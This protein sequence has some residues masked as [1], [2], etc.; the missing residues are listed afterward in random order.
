MSYY[1]F[2]FSEIYLSFFLN[3]D[4]KSLIFLSLPFTWTMNYF[5]S[6]KMFGASFS[7]KPWA[8]VSTSLYF[9]YLNYKPC[10]LFIYLFW[11][12]ETFL[13]SYSLLFLKWSN[14]FLKLIICYYCFEL[15]LT[16]YK[17][18]FVKF[19]IKAK[20]SCLKIYKEFWKLFPKWLLTF[21]SLG[22]VLSFLF[23]IYFTYS[24]R[25]F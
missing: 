8:T 22:L 13:L 7:I 3:A 5:Q 15:F 16:N 24:S 4:S 17:Y 19:F 11:R 12:S 23:L 14:V 9:S 10:I 1:I 2:A 20:V 21:S 6:Y 18:V 25:A